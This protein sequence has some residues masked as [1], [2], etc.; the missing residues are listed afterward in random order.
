MCDGGSI[1]DKAFTFHVGLSTLTSIVRETAAAIWDCLKD[2]FLSWPDKQKWQE[3]SE[4]FWR[5]WN[6][7]MALGAV[8]GMHVAIKVS[9]VRTIT[10]AQK[11]P[12]GLGFSH[13]WESYILDTWNKASSGCGNEGLI[14]IVHHH[15]CENKANDIVFRF[16]VQEILVRYISITNISSRSCCWLLWTQIITSYL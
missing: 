11:R 10:S 4:E 9:K 8:D 7:P 16:S 2:E 12:T 5:K 1:I 15:T 6:Y 3:I 14:I 13:S